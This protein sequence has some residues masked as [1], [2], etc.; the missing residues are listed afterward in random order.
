MGD[1]KEQ[2]INKF[3]ISL[4]G[5]D[6]IKSD[7]DFFAFIKKHKKQLE[8]WWNE[9]FLLVDSYDNIRR[10][11]K[12]LPLVAYRKDC[13]QTWSNKYIHR[14]SDFLITNHKGEILLSKRSNDKDT[15]PWY[16]ETWGGHCGLLSYDETLRKEIKEELWIGSNK[17][18]SIKKIMKLL[19]KMP[20]QR[21]YAQFYEVNLKKWASINIDNKEVKKSVWHTIEK[22]IESTQKGTLNIVPAQVTYLLQHILTRQMIQD[23]K[24]I[25]TIIKRQKE[26]YKKESIQEVHCKMF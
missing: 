24:I 8:C 2:K 11:K 20:S 3:L 9:V 4:P 6:K 18:N 26:L 10:N 19:V 21:E 5:F 14:A 16:W 13:H 12:G 7:I 25:D 22:I 23:K 1:S 17:I 15:Y